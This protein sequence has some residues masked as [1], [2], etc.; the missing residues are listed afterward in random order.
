VQ[1]RCRSKLQALAEAVTTAAPELTQE[2]P[3]V[4]PI[5]AFLRKSPVGGQAAWL[6]VRVT[7]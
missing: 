1:S 7:S 5:S 4:D 6:G 3:H 2:V